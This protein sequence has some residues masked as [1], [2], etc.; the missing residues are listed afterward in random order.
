M[1][2]HGARIQ[3]RVVKPDNTVRVR[4]LAARGMDGNLQAHA[5]VAPAKGGCQMH[6][7]GMQGAMSRAW[8]AFDE[9][10]CI[11]CPRAMIGY[12]RMRHAATTSRHGYDRW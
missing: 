5:P 12:M 3:Q 6:C 2:R 4:W 8:R 7:L 1:R 11:A 10:L 9:D